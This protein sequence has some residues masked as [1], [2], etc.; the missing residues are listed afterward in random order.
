MT[1]YRIAEQYRQFTIQ[2]RHD[3]KEW[4]DLSAIPNVP[5]FFD[6]LA[7]A[8][9]WV[10][11]IKKGVVYHDAEAPPLSESDLQWEYAR[12]FRIFSDRLNHD[13]EDAGRQWFVDRVGKMIRHRGHTFKITDS[14]HANRLYDASVLFGHEYTDPIDDAPNL[15][16]DERKAEAGVVGPRYDLGWFRRRIGSVVVLRDTHGNA[17]RRTLCDTDDAG[18]AFAS[19][20]IPDLRY[21]DP[22]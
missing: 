6:S 4:R 15:A 8:R 12:D 3:G 22:Q 13:A 20:F 2:V 10:A 1:E 11:T 9:S 14:P 7:D 21:S 16:Q 18:R 19:Q 5:R 17:M